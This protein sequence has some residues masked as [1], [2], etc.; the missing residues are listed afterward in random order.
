MNQFISY[1]GEFLTNNKNT[2]NII[3]QNKTINKL[4][5][6][7]YF[8]QIK[9]RFIINYK[10]NE[11]EI[12]NKIKI[13]EKKLNTIQ[14][15]YFIS[16]IFL[17]E[18]KNLKFGYECEY[19]NNKIEFYTQKII[20]NKIPNKLNT[21]FIII[22]TIKDLFN[23]S[24]CS[25]KVIFYD[26]YNKK[27][28]PTKK[29]DFINQENCNSA[30]CTVIYN[31]KKNGDIVLFR[32][33]ELI[34]VLIHELLHANFVDYKI[35]HSNYQYELTNDICTSYS[36]LINEAFTETLSSLLNMIYISLKTELTI[37]II[38]ENEYNHM[39]YIF[40]KILNHYN[41]KEIQDILK[42]NGCK[43]EFKQ[44]TNVFS[45]YVLKML[46]YMFID[47][48]L[49]LV[50]KCTNNNFIIDNELFNQYY[51]EFTLKHIEQLNKIIYKQKKIK[52]KNIRL[53]LYELK[54]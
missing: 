39:I 7:K 18:I 20:K 45:Y 6:N 26:L 3:F 28:L 8:N 35:I 9:N 54:L 14:D 33:E 22:Q 53:T 16:P 27:K 12:Q 15:S 31:E 25:Q 10:K 32:N 21:M 48:F 5:K 42:N 17:N 24:Y 51:I 44:K 4:N 1:S 36:I 52:G 11:K 37:N 46:N 29:E 34:K 49:N 2:N 47:E 43:K 23:R 40:N 30:F 19:L 38:Y 13:K 41:I 50:K